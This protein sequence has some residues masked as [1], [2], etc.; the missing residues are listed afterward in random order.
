MLN[1]VCVPVDLLGFSVTVVVDNPQVR[2]LRHDRCLD[3]VPRSRNDSDLP[4]VKAAER[5]RDAVCV[6]HSR[7]QGRARFNAP[8]AE[9]HGYSS[10]RGVCTVEHRRCECDGLTHVILPVGW[11]QIDHDKADG[12]CRGDNSDF[13]GGS[14]LRLGGG[15]SMAFTVTFAATVCLPAADHLYGAVAPPWSFVLKPANVTGA[16][17][18]LITVKVTGTPCS[19]LLTPCTVALMTEVVPTL[20][21]L[22]PPGMARARLGDTQLTFK[23]PQ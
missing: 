19:A 17:A 11:R 16:P 13:K 21:L 4:C 5:D 7:A 20:M 1:I 10:H 3:V 6:T 12:G 23:G 8:D 14:S 9:T 2:W 15:V 18:R 22:L